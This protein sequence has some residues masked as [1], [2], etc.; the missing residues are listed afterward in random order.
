MEIIC[1]QEDQLADIAKQIVDLSSNRKCWVFEGEM[2]AGK[3][4]TIKE[5][6]K[7][8]KVIDHVSSPTYSI[9]NE[10][11]TREN[12]I[13]YHFDFYRI[14]NEIEAIDIGVEE[15]FDSGNLCLIEWAEKIPSLLPLQYFKIKILTQLGQRIFQLN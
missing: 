13:I 7:I 5:I 1:Q 2:G 14:E 12:K 6:C 15:Y 11:L 8:L 4:T 3:T 9:I 10:Y